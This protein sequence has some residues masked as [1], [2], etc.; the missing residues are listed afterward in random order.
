MHARHCRRPRAHPRR[1]SPSRPDRRAVGVARAAA[2]QASVAAPPRRWPLRGLIDG[3]RFRFWVG[4]PWRDVPARY[5]PR[6]RVHALLSCLQ[7]PGIWTRVEALLATAGL[8]RSTGRSR[9][10]PPRPARTGMPPARGKTAA[11][12]SPTNPPTTRWAAREVAGRPRST[13]PATSIDT[14]WPISSHPA[15]PGDSPQMI[16]VLGLPGLPLDQSDHPGPRRSSS[17]PH[18]RWA[19]TRYDKPAVRYTTPIT[20]ANVDSWLRRPT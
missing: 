1:C 11:H 17:P 6:W 10:T 3:V 9:S 7:L 12:A 18:R 2:A 15:R 19:T 5:G 14:C 16:P 20:V 8:S 13:W 4:C